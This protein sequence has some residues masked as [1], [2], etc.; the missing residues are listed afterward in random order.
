[1]KTNEQATKARILVIEDEMAIQRGLCDVL[2]FHGHAPTGADTG[3]D[4][5][6]EGLVGQY[7]LV[8]LDIMLPGKSGFD[9]CEELRAELPRLPILML[10]ARGS[11]E[12]VVRGFRCGS[13]DYV[14]KPFSIAE[15]MARVDAL[16]RRASNRVA[17]RAVPFALGVVQ[18]DPERRVATIG[19]AE[20][21]LSK[22]EIELMA[23]LAQERGRIVSRRTLLQEVWGFD[24]PER[25]ETR[26]VDMHIANLRKKLGD[27]RDVIETVRGEGYR[28]AG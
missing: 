11:E 18:V 21:E 3:E 2:A 24:R 23:L 22:R 6:R 9:V 26:T 5:L 8:L 1:M 14:T 19:D 4:G 13:D 25:L 17:V 16:L 7:D 28:V 20:V 27:A 12:D 15:L 10:T